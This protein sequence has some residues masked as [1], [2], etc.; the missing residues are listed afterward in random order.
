M[1]KTAKLAGSI[2]S[3]VVIGGGEDARY[4]GQNG[5]EV[6]SVVSHVSDKVVITAE[7]ART[8]CPDCGV[9]ISAD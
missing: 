6:I 7:Q 4:C 3:P 2:A 1:L 5:Y 8:I 9:V